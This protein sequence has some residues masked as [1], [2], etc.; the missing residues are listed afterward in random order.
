VGVVGAIIP[1]NFPLLIAVRKI[2]SALATGLYHP[3]KDI[4]GFW[5]ACDRLI[6]LRYSVIL[7]GASLSERKRA[8]VNHP[9]IDFSK[10]KQFD[11]Q[12]KLDRFRDAAPRVTISPR[13]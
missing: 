9:D 10:A 2:D 1:W 8:A 11:E 4:H 6:Y 13:V 5:L 3:V 7:L 12:L